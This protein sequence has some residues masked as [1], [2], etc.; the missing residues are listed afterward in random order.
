MSKIN[1]I[2]FQLELFA[3]IYHDDRLKPTHISLLLALFQFWNQYHFRLF[4]VARSEIMKLAKISS[5]TTYSKCLTELTE[6]EYITYNKSTNPLIGSRFNLLP[7]GTN[8]IE[9]FDS[10]SPNNGLDVVR[11]SPKNGLATIDTSPENGLVMVDTGPKN[12]LDV[13]PYINLETI[14]LKNYKREKVNRKLTIR[15]FLKNNSNEKL[16]FKFFNHYDAVGWKTGAGL[17]I[18]NWKSLAQKWIDEEKENGQGRLVQKM[19]QSNFNGDPD[20][21]LGGIDRGIKKRYDE[22]F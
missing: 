6:W 7:N 15:Y 9:K 14:K 21:K 11:T 1:Y 12:G 3:R 18:V 19:D 10:T 16:A 2:Q 13:V 20:I 5:K 22:P 8:K 4:S 17:E